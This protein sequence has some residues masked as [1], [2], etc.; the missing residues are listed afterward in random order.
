VLDTFLH[1]HGKIS[2]I[3]RMIFVRKWNTRATHVRV[4]DGLDFVEIEM[5]SQMV[6]H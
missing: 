4:A 1:S 3:F 5:R 2:Y 6:H